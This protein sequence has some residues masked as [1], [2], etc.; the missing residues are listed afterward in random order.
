MSTA[1]KR[2]GPPATMN[3]GRHPKV[4]PTTL[5]MVKPMAAPTGM[6]ALKMLITR[7]RRL[8]ANS[9][10][11]SAGATLAY[12]ASP[13]PLT[14]RTSSRL[15]KPI[16]HA[17][18]AVSRLQKATAKASMCSRCTRSASR[19]KMGAVSVYTRMKAE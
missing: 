12:A 13:S 10:A 15:Q 8:G 5:P 18:A 6:A 11:R 19:P 14:E 16:A 9:S 2:P 1:S 7:L 4:V 3:A 17:P